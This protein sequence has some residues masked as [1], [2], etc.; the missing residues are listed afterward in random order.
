MGR[1]RR[2]GKRIQ[3]KILPQRTRRTRRHTKKR[4]E[5]GA[6]GQRGKGSKGNTRM[7]DEV[8]RDQA[9]GRELRRGEPLPSGD[10]YL[11][12][13]VDDWVN[14]GQHNH[15]RLTPGEGEIEFDGQCHPE[16]VANLIKD[17]GK[18]PRHPPKFGL[19]WPE[20]NRVL[21]FDGFVVRIGPTSDIFDAQGR[22]RVVIELATSGPWVWAEWDTAQRGGEE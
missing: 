13:K 3:I 20:A 9:P 14:I 15:L 2:K 11:F 1:R 10:C 6:K 19:V 5:E 7:S 12:I 4:G 8:A 18:Y 22:G 21:A 16:A 17:L